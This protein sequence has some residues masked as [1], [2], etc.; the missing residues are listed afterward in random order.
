MK[1]FDGETISLHMVADGHGP[2]G[3]MVSKYIIRFFP[4]ILR[5]L[6]EEGYKEADEA[7]LVNEYQSH[8]H[9]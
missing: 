6:I 9:Y 1:N 4:E 8:G 2:Q 7:A 5:R 3:H